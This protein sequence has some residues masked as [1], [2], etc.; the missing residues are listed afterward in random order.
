MEA[1]DYEMQYTMRI[2]C[3]RMLQQ[4]LVRQLTPCRNIARGTGV[5][6]QHFQHLTHGKPGQSLLGAQ[7]RQ[8][9][10]QATRVQL[11]VDLELFAHVDFR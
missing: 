6:R 3:G 10:A 7:Q 11:T 5:G 2:R 1:S 9:T 4:L 8:G